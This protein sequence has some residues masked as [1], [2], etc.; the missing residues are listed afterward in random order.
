[1]NLLV[2]KIIFAPRNF[3]ELETQKCLVTEASFEDFT[4]CDPSEVVEALL[5]ETSDLDDELQRYIRQLQ[6]EINTSQAGWAKLRNEKNLFVLAMML[7][8]WL[9]CLKVPV[10]RLE[11]LEHIVIYYKQPETC[12]QKF[13]IVSTVCVLCCIAET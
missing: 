6:N 8:E 3:Q 9:E 10:V 4:I 1:M 5:A 12:F 7:Y 11:Y 13:D 2:K